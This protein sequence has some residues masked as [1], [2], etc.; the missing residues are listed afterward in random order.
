MRSSRTNAWSGFDASAS[1][2][3]IT[4]N[5]CASTLPIRVARVD[6]PPQHLERLRR[7]R[8]PQPGEQ[9]LGRRTVHAGTRRHRTRERLEQRPVEQPLV[10]PA[11][12]LGLPFVL[13]L[14][15]GGVRQP[16]RARE[17]GARVRIRGEVVRL[18]VADDLQAML[19]PAQE[20]VRVGRAPRR[21][22]ARRIPPPRAWPARATCSAR[23]ASG[24]AARARSAAAA[25]RTPRRGCRRGRASPRSAPCRGAGCTPPAGPWCGGRRRSRGS[26]RSSGYTNGATPSTNAEPI[27]GSPATDRALII[28]WR[29]HVADWCS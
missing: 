24:R 2:G 13:V 19:Q 16:E 20:P 28:A 12:Q 9:L 26:P 5:T 1:A 11:D 27:H 7:R 21:R 4:G 18:Q 15:R 3:T 6:Q 22:P 23:A 8:E 10:D 14:Q 25:P 17:R 29:S